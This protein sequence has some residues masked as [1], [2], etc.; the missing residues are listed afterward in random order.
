LAGA[1]STSR[2]AMRSVSSW[3]RGEGWRVAVMAAAL[4]ALPSGQPSI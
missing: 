3:I 1:S 2:A 4:P